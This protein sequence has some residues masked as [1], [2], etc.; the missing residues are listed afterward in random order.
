MNEGN[1]QF[2]VPADNSLLY[3]STG[4]LGLIFTVIIGF[5]IKFWLDEKNAKER[6]ERA[7]ELD[8]NLHG[9]ISKAFT[10]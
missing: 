5:A 7:A 3:L 4:F 8:R 10:L 9:N 2:G 6:S 1:P